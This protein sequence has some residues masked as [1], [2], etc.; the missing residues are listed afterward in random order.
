MGDKEIAAEE[1]QAGPVNENAHREPASLVTLE[2]APARRQLSTLPFSAK[3]VPF[4]P[5]GRT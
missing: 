3:N 5:P 1:L 2:T 4:L